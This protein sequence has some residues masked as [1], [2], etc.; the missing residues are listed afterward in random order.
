MVSLTRFSQMVS[1]VYAAALSPTG[2]AEAM[3]EI[4]AGFTQTKDGTVRSTTLALADGVSRSMIGVLLPPAENTYHYYGRIDHVLQ[5]V[6]RGRAG[7]ARTSDELIAPYTS[8]EFY[9]DWVRPNNL[10]HGI[11]V[12]LTDDEKPV[13]FI[14]AGSK[15][16][17]PFDTEERTELFSSLIPHMQQALRIQR[18][19]TALTERADAFGQAVQRLSHGVVIVTKDKQMV[20][21]NSAAAQLLSEREA[22]RIDDGKLVASTPS[23]EQTLRGIAH[24][25]LETDSVRAGG[26]MICQRVSGSRPLVL[27][28]VPIT[29]STLEV[30]TRPLAMVLMV[31]PARQPR[32]LQSVLRQLYGLTKSEAAVAHLVMNGEGVQAISDQLSLSTATVRTHLR[33]IFSKTATH[34]QAELVRLLSTIVL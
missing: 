27:H 30:P 15:G 6:E 14:V 13:S 26:S 28:V 31:D 16:T 2:W 25:A 9:L 34:R 32:P 29:S 33:A 8:T 3:E 7:T 12:R 18:H 4:H 21:C 23:D 11:F 22:L 24:H 5:A 20:E 10:E 19:L 17:R 1:L